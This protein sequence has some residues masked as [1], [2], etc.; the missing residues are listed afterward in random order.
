MKT[1]NSLSGGKTS[2]YL[3]VHYPAD[4]ELFSL[5][6]LD[7]HNAAGSL[8]RDRK[9]MQMVNDKLE[10]YQSTY[11]TFKATPEDP[12]TIK[13]MFNLE[14]KI[15]REIKWVRGESFEKVMDQKKAIPNKMMRFCTYEMK[16]KPIFDYLYT[17]T[18][19]PVEMRIGYRYD[20]K[21][22]ADRASTRIRYSLVGDI[23]R[24]KHSWNEMEWRKNSFPMIEDKVGHYHVQKYWKGKGFDFPEDSNCQH[25][26][27]KQD[28][29][30]RKNF[31]TNP[32]IM[33]WA[34]IQ[35]IIRGKTFDKRP[36]ENTKKIGLQMGFSFGTGS[37]CQ[38]GFCTD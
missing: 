35:E 18:A 13:V 1:V 4:I 16:I 37:G 6:C 26:F 22:R 34:S 36:L 23:V 11:G 7:D 21:D 5:V 25:C 15:G 9:L 12:K 32:S 38:A 8:K 2:S 10:A 24:K 31:D 20:E 14:Q 17:H 28:Q 33:Q 30:K 3:A 19:L 27:W 29:Q